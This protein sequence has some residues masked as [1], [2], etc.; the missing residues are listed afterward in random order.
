MATYNG[1]KFIQ[2][3][4][5]SILEQLHENDE[6]IISDDGSQDKT[7]N[8]ISNFQDNRIK[9]LHGNFH[10]PIFNFENAIKHAKGDFIFLSDQ[11]DEW[12]PHRIEKAMLLHNKGYDLVVTNRLE[13]YPNKTNIPTNKNPFKKFF[14]RNLIK[15]CFT[16]CCMSFSR[17][18]AE[19]VLPFPQKIAM[20][21]LWIGLLGQIK[22]NCAYI[23]EPTI[24][25]NRHEE[26]FI[27]K[28]KRSFINQISYRVTILYLIIKRIL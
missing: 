18:L 17:Q 27:V 13:I 23:N 16:G 3:Q 9:I 21:D 2:K 28:H 6:I 15:P 5:S 19:Y 12:L 25:Y 1:E 4:L 24:K 22:F 20:H 14:L 26:S 10:S 11:D 7:I 8:I